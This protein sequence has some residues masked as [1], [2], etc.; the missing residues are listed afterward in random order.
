MPPRRG[1]LTKLGAEEMMEKAVQNERSKTERLLLKMMREAIRASHRRLVVTVN[2]RSYD[3]IAFLIRGYRKLRGENEISVIYVAPEDGDGSNFN[4]L[5]ERVNEE[6]QVK[7][8]T[9]KFYTYAESEHLLGT[10]ND[11][12]ILDMSLGA[13]PNDIGRLVETVRGGGLVILHNLR[14]DADKGWETSLHRR[15][16]IPPYSPEDINVRFERYFIRKLLETKGIWILDG[17]RIIKGE[18]LNPP[19]STRRRP[20]IPKKSRVPRR[21]H[22]LTLTQEQCDALQKLEEIVHERGRSVL[23]IISDRGRGKSALLGL[24]AA[25]LLYLGAKRILVTAPNREETQVIFE[26]AER[27][28]KA[29]DERVSREFS[30]EW[31][32][33]IKCRF[34]SLE[35]K[36]PHKVLG[37][38]ADILM[39]DEAAS[40]PVPQLF[41]FIRRFRKVI[42]A[43]TIHGYEGAGRGFSLRF[44][45]ALE[46]DGGI[47]LHRMELKEPIRY[48]LGDPVEEWLY[49]A[50]LLDAEPAEVGEDEVKLEECTYEEADLDSWFGEEEDKLREF[51][52]IYVLAHYRN[53][54]DDLLILGDAPHHLAR[55][56]KTESGKI[57]AA[58][59]LAEEGRMPDEMVTQ[60]LSGNPPS[61]NLIPSCI[62]KYYPPYRDFTRFRGVRIV[63][64]AVHPNFLGRGI[65]SFALKNLCEEM[66]RKGFDWVGAAFGADRQLLNFWLKNGFIPVHISPMRNIVSGEFSVVLVKPLSERAEGLIGEIYREFKMRFLDALPDVYYNLDPYVAVGLL[67]IKNIDFQAESKLTPS[68]RGRLIEYVQGSVSYEGACDSVKRILS[69]H[70]LSSGRYRLDLEVRH[71][72]ELL[73][74]CLQCRSWDRTAEIV[75][76][77]SSEVKSDLRA[78]VRRLV[79]HYETAKLQEGI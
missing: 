67:S 33:K 34:G 12:L 79:D 37:E 36:Y 54:P 29:L 53:R 17:W 7:D 74:R 44:L 60:I 8:L 27:S 52:G 2:D 42:F 55:M 64:I 32:S 23:V 18:L 50:L 10:T 22:R 61:G 63:R 31:V 51:I 19:K 59:H 70:F 15:L 1:F 3:V 47:N 35:F 13:R 56:V 40:I 30:E 14:L 39:V 49:K 20:R 68:Q 4:A 11:I 24:G 77:R 75:G 69:A 5:I 62:V 9:V 25:A 78:L 58:L 72:V 65:G 6:V 46:E 16:I 28:L 76:A 73:C 38:R 43:S 48:A 41:R 26:M 21:I 71:E 57:I 66:K 45:K